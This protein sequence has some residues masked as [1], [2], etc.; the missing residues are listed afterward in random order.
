MDT[1]NISSEITI[2]GACVSSKTKSSEVGQVS[3]DNK[4]VFY[5]KHLVAGR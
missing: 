3:V 4:K 2:V 5:F 1:V